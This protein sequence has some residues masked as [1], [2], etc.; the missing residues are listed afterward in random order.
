M[1]A[2]DRSD[3]VQ[4]LA[5]VAKVSDFE[6]SQKFRE[7]MERADPS[8]RDLEWYVARS[9]LLIGLRYAEDSEPVEVATRLVRAGEFTYPSE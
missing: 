6:K 9:Y 7:S 3:A 2:S 4:L 8:R 1:N 5:M